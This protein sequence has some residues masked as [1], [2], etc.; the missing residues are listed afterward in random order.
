MGVGLGVGVAGRVVVR[1]CHHRVAYCVR[2]VGGWVSG[3]GVEGMGLKGES[4]PSWLA[5]LALAKSAACSAW[6]ACTHKRLPSRPASPRCRPTV[7]L[8]RRRMPPMCGP[9]PTSQ[10]RP[11]AVLVSLSAAGP[12]PASPPA[13][14]P[15]S[16]DHTR[17]SQSG[18]GAGRKAAG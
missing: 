12:S 9:S 3:F 16:L 15:T 13:G 8:T 18:R 5:R 10:L 7:A 2:G 4:R 14:K 6:A 1:V 11:E 17:Y